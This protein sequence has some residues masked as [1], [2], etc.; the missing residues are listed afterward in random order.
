MYNIV[1]DV[2]GVSS[3]EVVMLLVFVGAE[4]VNRRGTSS[5]IF[6]LLWVLRM[7]RE[8]ATCTRPSCIRRALGLNDTCWTLYIPCLKAFSS[9]S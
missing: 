9:G 7:S 1:P 6:L 3:L 4:Y 5:I 2:I 8:E